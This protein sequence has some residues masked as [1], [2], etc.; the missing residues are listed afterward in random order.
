MNDTGKA[1]TDTP[2]NEK[3]PNPN[4]KNEPPQFDWINQRSNCSLPRV[5]ATLRSQIEQDVKTR[6]SLRPSFAPYEFSLSEDTAEIVVRLQAKDLQKSVVFSLGEHAICVRDDEGN[7]MF[8]VTLTFDDAGRCKLN[9]N[10]QERD[11]WQVRRMA[12]EDLMFRGL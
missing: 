1:Q 9:V 7:R 4:A 11:F 5:F 3:I 2:Q 6:N 8:D 12:L 10:G